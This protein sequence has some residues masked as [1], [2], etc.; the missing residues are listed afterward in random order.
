MALKEARSPCL[1]DQGFFQSEEN[2][3]VSIAAFVL[4]IHWSLLM[5]FN[6]TFTENYVAL[7]Y[8]EVFMI[9]SL[10]GKLHSKELSNARV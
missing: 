9:S 2:R 5:Q 6:D 7:S 10:L 3:D 4:F 8:A 1:C